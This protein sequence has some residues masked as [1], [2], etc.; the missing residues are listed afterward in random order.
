[1]LY[2]NFCCWPNVQQFVLLKQ[3]VL[4]FVTEKNH[5]PQITYRSS[6]R[7]SW[8]SS[9]ARRANERPTASDKRMANWTA[10]MHNTSPH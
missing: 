10:H 4:Y 8:Q 6:N 1:M 3:I 5:V 9:Q 2:S 7:E